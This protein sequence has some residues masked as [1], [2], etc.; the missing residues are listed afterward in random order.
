MTQDL[1]SINR[2][3]VA[4]FLTAALAACG[5]GNSTNE[6][7]NGVVPV[8]QQGLSVNVSAQIDAQR[9]ALLQANIQSISEKCYPGTAALATPGDVSADQ[10]GPALFVFEIRRRDV[11]TATSLGF[12]PDFSTQGFNLEAVC[13]TRNSPGP[14]KLD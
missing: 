11:A 5:G 7:P 1:K 3:C 4:C 13:D 8:A 2:F 9:K 6:D 12:K 10:R 14:V